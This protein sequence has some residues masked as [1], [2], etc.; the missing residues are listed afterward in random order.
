MRLLPSRLAILFLAAA[1]CGERTPSIPPPVNLYYWPV[2]AAIAAQPAGTSLLVVSTNYDL[3]YDPFSGGTVIAVDPAVPGTVGQPLTT[4]GAARIASDGGVI[5]IA[6][7]S[8]C[9]IPQSVAVVPSRYTRVINRLGLDAAGAPSCG[10]A[11]VVPI[12]QSPGDPFGLTVACTTARHDAFV[13]FLQNAGTTPTVAAVDLDLRT[14]PD[15]AVRTFTVGSLGSVY[16]AAYDE[17][18]DRLYLTIIGD[19]T[20][21]PIQ[22]IAL[23]ETPDPFQTG[24][25]PPLLTTFDLTPLLR[26]AEVRGIALSNPQ[27]GLTRRAY[28]S[29]RVFDADVANSIAGRPNYDVAGFLA[30]LDLPEGPLGAPLPQLIRLVPIGLGVDTLRVLPVRAPVAGA[31]VRDLVAV[32]ATDENTAQLYDDEQGVVRAITGTSTGPF[33]PLDP[34]QPPDPS[35][36]LAG[37]PQMGKQPTG[38]AVEQRTATVGGVTKPFDF[39][40]VS[41]FFTSVVQVLRVDPDDPSSMTIVYGYGPVRAQ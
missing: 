2:S 1:A 4:L 36:L 11:C 20:T 22:V 10:D 33:N 38:L 32:L 37:V 34:T 31:P 41:S 35:G 7:S 24:T 12:P 21:A 28:V 3:A 30:V 13:G 15:Q 6:S 29:V 5:G 39:I 19:V 17:V 9:A 16:G 23:G 14:P 26:G 8:A 18:F 27:P 25:P 40:Y